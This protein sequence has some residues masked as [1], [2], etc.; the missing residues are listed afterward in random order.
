MWDDWLRDSVGSDPWAGEC[1]YPARVYQRDQVSEA[2]T[3]LETFDS[4]LIPSA[5]GTGKT[6]TF[7]HIARLWPHLA[8]RWGLSERVLVLAHREELISQAA[9]KIAQ[10]CPDEIVEVEQ[11]DRR[12]DRAM[13]GGDL[14]DP[15]GKARSRIVVAS[16]D[17][18]CE[19]KRLRT[20]LP[21]EFGL[22]IGD[23]A[24]RF[25]PSNRSYW[26]I[27]KYFGRAKLIGTTAT[28]DRTDA[29][30]LRDAFKSYCKPFTMFDAIK[31]GW[32]VSIVQQYLAIE[33]LDLSDIP[34][35]RRRDEGT[36]LNAAQ[37]AERLSQEKPLHAIAKAA[38][39]YS[40][41]RNAWGTSR[42]TLI[43][44]A[45]VHHA[46][47]IAAI[48]NDRH[49]RDGTGIA[50]VIHSDGMSS[51]ERR[52]IIA[53]YRCGIVRYLVNYGILTEGFDAPE[54]RIVLIARPTMSRAL[55]EQMIGRGTR[56][57]DTIVWALNHAESATERREIILKSQ[58]PSVLIIDLVGNSGVHKLI[59]AADILGGL[60]EP[61]V[62]QDAV[63]RIRNRGMGNVIEI[64]EESRQRKKKRD[65][66]EREKMRGVI[67]DAKWTA[68][69]VDPFNVWDLAVGR[70][71]AWFKNRPASEPQ[72]GVL[73]RAGFKEEELKDIGMHRASRII[74]EVVRR[75]R[76]GLCTWGQAKILRKYH[77]DTEMTFVEAR[78]AIDDLAARGWPKPVRPT[79][80]PTTAPTP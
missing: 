41:K 74:D 80:A 65:D 8:Q 58:K 17:T 11:G 53:D 5:T 56:P 23:E 34:A 30:S 45:S 38:V 32:L 9:E 54:T 33:E 18:L 40:N 13:W 27:R 55:Y 57:H 2:F 29:R 4:C 62:A 50:A 35:V 79:A 24:H 37:L 22:I 44:A 15:S 20:F 26:G 10:I 59:G 63:E 76:E 61:E 39:E 48:L 75:R 67:V 14:F 68:R 71:P 1:K 60:Q 31:D 21:E 51:D 43:F 36:D 6:V 72:L 28:P 19:T 66:E 12:A 47:R 7:G 64:I 73:R 69:L 52:K 46:K 3:N 42:P 16:K 70:E 25:V 49:E 77:L 78:T